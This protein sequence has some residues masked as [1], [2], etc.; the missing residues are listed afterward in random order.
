MN[1]E[2]VTSYVDLLALAGRDTPLRRVA[3]TGGGEYAGPCPFCG[4][5]DRFRVQPHRPRPVWWCRGCGE[6]RWHDALDYVARRERLDLH[7]A[8]DFRRA[9]ELLGMVDSLP[10]RPRP[11][12]CPL[13]GVGGLPPPAPAG[14]PPDEWQAKARHVIAECVTALWSQSGA[15]ARAWLHARGLTDETLRRWRIG[16]H[17]GSGYRDI[18]GLR[19]PCG[20]IIPCEVGGVVWYVNVRR[21]VGEPKYQKVKGSRAA[22]FGAE[23][24]RGQQVAVLCEGEFDALLLHQQAG[25]LAGVATL[26]GASGT[27]D[28]TH[29][30]AY[31]LPLRR[32]LV[33]YDADGPGRKGAEKFVALTRR[34]RRVTLPALPGVKDLT[35]FHKA[36]GDL[37][38]WL[39][40]ELARI[41][42]VTDV[43]VSPANDVTVTGPNDVTCNDVT[44]AGNVTS[45]RPND[46]TV[47]A[48]NDVTLGANTVTPNAV[49]SGPD[50]PGGLDDV[51][52]NDVTLGADT[53]TAPDA[54]T[55]PANNDVTV[56]ADN[57]VTLD[58][59]SAPNDVTVTAGGNDVTL[60]ANTVTPNDV[61][62]DVVAAPLAEMRRV[63]RRR[64]ALTP[65][66]F[67]DDS[68][69]PVASPLD[70]AL[71]A[72]HRA[73]LPALPPGERDW[74]RV[75][76]ILPAADVAS[77]GDVVRTTPL[78]DGR[79]LA[80]WQR[81]K[82]KQTET[83]R[84]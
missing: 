24:L 68:E 57:A 66:A 10:S 46:V 40:F 11:T 54:V 59:E 7:R 51:T 47:T 36:G 74:E 61:T 25:D 39:A 48:G 70:P 29:F 9:C 58:S 72:E 18:G 83:T 55:P 2:T 32:L 52:C 17:P 31:L 62:A 4:G 64:A 3:G 69:T 41:H 30:G 63:L 50:S 82:G 78:A 5:R 45:I 67:R 21:A 27:P 26:G 65:A 28:L 33:A 60:G 6:G 20:I 38:A 37:R 49:T 44:P 12:P 73:A 15:K 13:K 71:L 77:L 34:A 75:T 1:V 22:L 35:D 19:V 81:P 16:Y 14:P 23:T 79:V 53:V 43:T 76:A 42:A 84:G 80:T 8:D 56:T